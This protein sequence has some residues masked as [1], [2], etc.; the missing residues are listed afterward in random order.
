MGEVGRGSLF[1]TGVEP[2]LEAVQGV[3]RHDLPRQTVPVWSSSREEHLPV[4][5][6]AGGDVIAVVVVLP[7]TTSAACWSWQVART[8]GHE[9][10]V[11]FEK[12]NL[13]F[14]FP[15]ALLKLAIPESP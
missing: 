6:S 3:S 4:L 8:D 14:G 1:Q 7:R 2:A 10:M 12:K 15:A 9:A 5:C 11:E 13:Q